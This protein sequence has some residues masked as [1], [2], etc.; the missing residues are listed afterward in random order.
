MELRNEPNVSQRL[1]LS[2]LVIV[3]SI[4]T[5]ILA[6]VFF[7]IGNFL[8]STKTLASG[9][10]SKYT[11]S[12]N[13]NTSTNTSTLNSIKPG[14]TILITGSLNV[15][16]NNSLLANKRVVIVIDGGELKWTNKR[17]LT[18]HRNA[19]VI[20]LNGGILKSDG[21]SNCD[22]DS[23]VIMDGKV[24]VNCDGKGSG[25]PATFSDVNTAGGFNFAGPFSGSNPSARI[26]PKSFEIKGDID[27]DDVEDAFIE[28]DNGDTIKVVDHLEIDEDSDLLKDKDVYIQVVNSKLKWKG[29]YALKLG[30][31]AKIK[32]LSGSELEASSS[33]QDKA[34]T[35]YFG[36]DKTVSYTGEDALNSF[37][38]VNAAGEI[39]ANG[40]APLPVELIRFDAVLS[41][42]QVKL[43]WVTA[44]EIN[45]SH[46]EVQRS[47]DLK[48]WEQIGT[49]QGNGNANHIIEYRFTDP[50]L[51]SFP[52]FYYRLRQVD[53][54]GKFEF[55]DI[56]VVRKEALPETTVKLFP[57]PANEQINIETGSDE[58]YDLTLVDMSGKPVFRERVSTS[59]F[60]VNTRDFP[61]GM[62]M[63][64]LES[65]HQQ[66][67]HKFIVR[68]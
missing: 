56:R 35:I 31:K 17:T 8:P 68:H 37:A 63:A 47:A 2:R 33:A 15:N 44:S 1:L 57:N 16:A 4:L 53:F 58:P 32:L 41:G 5:V 52:R 55:S 40:V 61:N 3:S 62:Y 50:R 26:F 46:F 10:A 13:I 29:K 24:V 43:F 59:F 25:S 51:P 45:N 64:I 60:M 48:T 67:T 49:V 23:R 7:S 20:L 21:G 36:N 27:D 34:T 30:P 54:D 65:A 18:L 9:T 38:D 66:S 42:E 28:A 6:I 39:D 19:K 12:G 22:K 11:M 14:D